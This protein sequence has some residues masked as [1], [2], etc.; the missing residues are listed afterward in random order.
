M[1]SWFLIQYNLHLYTIVCPKILWTAEILRPGHFKYI[2]I[3]Q[4][5]YLKVLN[6]CRQYNVLLRVKITIHWLIEK[7]HVTKI[8]EDKVLKRI[9]IGKKY[10]IA[11]R[12]YHIVTFFGNLYITRTFLT[13]CMML[14]TQRIDIPFVFLLVHVDG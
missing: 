5:T 8:D 2:T 12:R 11:D 13:H 3:L 1:Q 10:F 4:I 7:T 6:A 9:K 14:S